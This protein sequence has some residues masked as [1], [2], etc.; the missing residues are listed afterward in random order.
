MSLLGVAIGVAAVIVLTGLGE[1]ARIYVTGEFMQLGTNLLLV[2]PGKIETSGMAPIFG[3][4]PHELTVEDADAISRF[5]RSARAVAPFTMGQAA[6]R[7]GQ[8]TR[9]VTVAGTTAAFRGIRQ[10][11]IRLG[12][13]LPASESRQAQRVCVIGAKV[14]RELFSG[15]NPLGEYLRLGEGR[16]R[17]IGVME[18]RGTSLG[19][20]L[21][22][23]VH[24]PVRSG[25]RMFNQSGL[26]RIFV[27]VRS[28]EEIEASK[29]QVL[30]LLYD[31]HGGV[32]DVTIVTQDSVL[33]T[34]G[35]ILA[36]LTA[37][38]GGIAA[39]S[40]TVAGIGI[41]NVML[42]SVS[43]RTSE[44]GLLKSLGASRGQILACFLV[45]AAIISSAGGA[46]G[47]TAGFL[48]NRSVTLFYPSFPVQPPGWAVAGAV[49]V[50]ILVGVLFGALPARRAARLDP[51]T[52]LARR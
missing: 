41:M 35:N 1:G 24:V 45:E 46:L 15:L 27:E 12:T 26:F 14:Q 5:V 7:Y 40:L 25:M 51:V 21:D 39:I 50:S 32:E 22:E 49:A 42:V 33:S 48:L 52:A 9:D 36:T 16:F 8:T 23:I 19:M 28:H 20:N 13:Y 29:R 34:F 3:G 37:A 4:V 11:K 31:R 17:I 44:I 10:F 6:A 2:M 30:D 47:L 38:L 43:E 18:P